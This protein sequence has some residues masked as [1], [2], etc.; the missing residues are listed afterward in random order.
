M[1]PMYQ[2]Y[3]QDW[4]FQLSNYSGLLWDTE[5]HAQG[6]SLIYGISFPYRLAQIHGHWSYGSGAIFLFEWLSVVTEKKKT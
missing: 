4:V 3:P 2:K 5:E 6:L 1:G